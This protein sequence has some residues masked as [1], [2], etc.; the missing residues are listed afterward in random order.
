MPVLDKGEDVVMNIPVLTEMT[1]WIMEP[2]AKMG[3]SMEEMLSLLVREK[4]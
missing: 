3:T 1:R 2:S 4:L